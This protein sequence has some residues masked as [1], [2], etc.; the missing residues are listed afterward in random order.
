MVGVVCERPGTPEPLETADLPPEPLETMDDP[1]VP[2]ATTVELPETVG[3]T[4][5]LPETTG[6]ADLLF[7]PLET[8]D[9]LPET[10]ALLP[11]TTTLLPVPLE[12]TDWLPVPL[13]ATDW[14]S[15]PLVEETWAESGAIATH[16]VMKNKEITQRTSMGKAGKTLARKRAPVFK[17]AGFVARSG[18]GF[19]RRVFMI[20]VCCPIMG[21][22]CL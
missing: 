17:R 6:F 15:V 13:D 4:P 22:D 10:T 18:A 16:K 8:N 21:C 7:V 3:R 14:L 1:P 20:L 19:R 5:V 11:E 2:L 9:L 12:T